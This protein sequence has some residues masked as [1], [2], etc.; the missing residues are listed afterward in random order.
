MKAP[1]P[2]KYPRI[3]EPHKFAGYL[4]NSKLAPHKKIVPTD[5]LKKIIERSVEYASKKSSRAILEIPE[6][7][8]DEQVREIYLKEGCSLLAYF[9][10]YYGDPASTAYECEGRHCS[11]I[12]KEQFHSRT[13]Q[14]ERMNSGWRYQRIAYQCA[15]ASKRFKSVSDL[16]AVE[17]DFNVTV[18]T[19]DCPGIPIINIYISVKNRQNTL[20]GQDWPK[21]IYALEEVAQSDKNRSGPYICVFGI[22]MER[23]ERTIKRKKKTKQ[24]Y[25]FNTEV[26]LSDFFWPFVANHSYEAIMMAVSDFLEEQGVTIENRTIGVPVPNELIESFGEECRKLGLVD[27]EGKFNDRRKLVTFF[28]T[29]P[30]KAKKKPKKA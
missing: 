26:W 19:V 29:K 18:E 3:D 24:P 4:D 6:S 11:E 15:E 22:A 5:L 1:I 10:K 8:T 14:K 16:G 25:S 7:A 17:A 28:C 27:A 9:R 2:Q 23:G 13:L 30:A 21:A 20:G 12:A